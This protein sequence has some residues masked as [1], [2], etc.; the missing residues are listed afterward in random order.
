MGMNEEWGGDFCAKQILF[1]P[2]KET[3]H[4]IMDSKTEE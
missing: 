1:T 2:G 3:E 4:R